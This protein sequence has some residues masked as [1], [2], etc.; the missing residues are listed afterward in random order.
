MSGILDKKSRIFDFTITDNGREQ[1]ENNDIRYKYA[2]FSD[3]SII[4]TKDFEKSKLNKADVT[5][6]EIHYLPLEAITRGHN[7]I[8]PEFDLR[9]YYSGLKIDPNQGED[10]TV[11]GF[12]F[13]NSVNTYIQNYTLSSH[14][15]NL[16][17]LKTKRIINN[18]KSLTFF[19]N[20]SLLTKEID[21]HDKSKL[22]ST[23]KINKARKKRF[24]II[25][26]DKRFSHKRSFSYMP[27]KD[28]SGK[29]LYNKSNFK[30]IDHLEK[31]NVIGT[32]FSKYKSNSLNPLNPEDTREEN[33]VKIL[34]D[35]DINKGIFK[36]EF[37][38]ENPSENS[39]FIFE[40]HEIVE[41][42][43]SLQPP[44]VIKIELEKL[45]F[46]KI[47][48][49]YDKGSFTTKKVYLIGKFLNTR[50]NTKELDILFNFNNGEVNLKSKDAFSLSAFFSF[51]CLFT[52]VI[53]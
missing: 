31:D 28:I 19:D 42:F 39:N 24:P 52:L 45:H 20:N 53:E 50:D 47:G 11:E 10:T 8:N 16:K 14:L 13:N 29:D 48:S 18:N 17:Y 12:D 46:V 49:F 26:L 36:K 4:Y 30:H 44:S 22:Y 38:L 5:D 37:I 41:K 21:F 34:K 3:K 25:A 15:K 51:V 7:E 9:K 35:L 1:I 32:I 27:P 23:I 40:L 6:S 2:S 33:I 43:N